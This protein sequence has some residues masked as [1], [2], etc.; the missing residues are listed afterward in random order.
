M[1]QLALR[2]RSKPNNSK[3]ENEISDE[4]DISVD[5]LLQK[6]CGENEENDETY[7]EEEEDEQSED[8]SIARIIS[9]CDEKH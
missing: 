7:I 2:K 8:V 3:Y 6:S 9:Y 1:F 5:D 4:S